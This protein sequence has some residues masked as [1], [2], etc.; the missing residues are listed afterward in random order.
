[1]ARDGTMTR[2]KIMDAA[3]RLILEQGFGGTSID[4]VIEGAGV[5]KGT[6]FYNFRTKT[7]LAYQKSTMR[8]PSC[9]ASTV[10]VTIVMV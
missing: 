10:A 7:D 8:I 4:R 1:M 2:T 6:F 3:E 9:R 5:T